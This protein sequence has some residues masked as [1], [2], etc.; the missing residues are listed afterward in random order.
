M[1]ELPLCYSSAGCSKEAP[2][3]KYDFRPPPGLGLGKSQTSVKF[4]L[5]LSG[6]ESK[7]CLY[8]KPMATALLFALSKALL[9]VSPELLGKIC[10]NLREP[11]PVT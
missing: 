11:S 8:G 3:G 1:Q 7:E 2:W 4:T 10:G 9:F 6:S 5:L